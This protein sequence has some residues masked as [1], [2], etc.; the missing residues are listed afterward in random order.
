[1]QI[2][3]IML[4]LK[5]EVRS[6]YSLGFLNVYLHLCCNFFFSPGICGVREQVRS[7]GTTGGDTVRSSRKFQQNATNVLCIQPRFRDAAFR[8][9]STGSSPTQQEASL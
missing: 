8:P 1:M 5:N 2:T 6:A 9:Q 3:H 4:C 7:E